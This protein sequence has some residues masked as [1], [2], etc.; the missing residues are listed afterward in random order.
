MLEDC[1]KAACYTHTS[2]LR[3]LTA[4]DKDSSQC[5]KYMRE[6]LTMLLSKEPLVE[7]SP[8]Q[9]QSKLVRLKVL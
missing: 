7:V 9:S 2:N 4:D 1:S 3:M 6:R 8:Q 5:S